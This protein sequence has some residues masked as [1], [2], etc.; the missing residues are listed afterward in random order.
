MALLRSVGIKCRFHGF[1]IF[2]D[3]QRG[4]IT[5][6]WYLMSPKEIVHSW[7]EVFYDN[8]WYNLEGIILDI[9]YLNKLQNKY[10]SC[11]SDFCGFGA[12]TKSFQDPQIYWNENDTYIQKEGI[13]KD[14]GVFNNPDDFFKNYSQNLGKT[15]RFIYKH[16]IRHIMNRNVA[17]IR[18]TQ[19]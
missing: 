13:A 10:S 2:K 5:G 12:A 7:V 8:T 3:L 9:S 17:R 16:L 19:N 14:L 15:K 4:A 6:I 1:T 11:C 18:N